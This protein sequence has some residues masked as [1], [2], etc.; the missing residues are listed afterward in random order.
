M[1]RLAIPALFLAFGWIA[2]CTGPADLGPR[3]GTDYGAPPSK[4]GADLP[5]GDKYFLGGSVA[6]LPEVPTVNASPV[7]EV[8]LDVTHK[9]VELDNGVKFHGWT[10]GDD[11]PGP[12][13]RVRQ[14]DKVKFT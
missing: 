14:G 8:R 11:I 10:F 9:I 4:V 7:K 1:K 5:K 2:A 6:K 13:I 3:Y 12:T